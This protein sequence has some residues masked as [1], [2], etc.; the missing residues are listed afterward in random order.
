[1]VDW[2]PGGSTAIPS[3]STVG[4][5]AVVPLPLEVVPLK[6]TQRDI[7]FRGKDVGSD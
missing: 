2:D 7:G 5:L 4:V 1:M 3:G 6:M